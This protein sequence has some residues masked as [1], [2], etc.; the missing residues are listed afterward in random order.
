M[1]AGGQ[2]MLAETQGPG[3][4]KLR[5][6]RLLACSKSMVL[7]AIA[8]RSCC[9]WL[10][11]S[12]G[13]FCTPG[14]SQRMQD[15]MVSQRQFRWF[16]NNLVCIL[17]GCISRDAPC[18]VTQQV[19]AMF[20]GGLRAIGVVLVPCCGTSVSHFLLRSAITIAH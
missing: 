2:A 5:I 13:S 8:D 15:Q 7:F 4:K 11:I 9:D 14:H 12:L 6:S 17:N 1:V 19:A 18:L 3:K 20:A 10:P 16:Q